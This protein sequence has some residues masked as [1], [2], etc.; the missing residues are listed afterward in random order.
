MHR[1]LPLLPVGIGACPTASQYELAR[2]SAGARNQF[3]ELDFEEAAL[4]GPAQPEPKSVAGDTSGM[5]A[6]SLADSALLVALAGSLGSWTGGGRS[7]TDQLGGDMLE[8][9]KASAETRQG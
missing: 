9:A 2:P 7:M 8:S 1:T 6:V 5:V 4:S 3:L